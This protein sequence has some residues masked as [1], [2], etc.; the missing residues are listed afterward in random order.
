MISVFPHLTSKNKVCDKCC[1]K[2]KLQSTVDKVQ[3]V[4]LIVEEILDHELANTNPQ[5]NCLEDLDA[6]TDIHSWHETWHPAFPYHLEQI[7]FLSY[8]ALPRPNPRPQNHC[9]VDCLE[10]KNRKP[11][12]KID[13][14][15][16][17]HLIQHSLKNLR[18]K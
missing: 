16:N 3:H 11:F 17:Q 10:N 5:K 8:L 13:L 18:I 1:K 7:A 15:A 4:S 14:S 9:V 2:I 12:F 6:M